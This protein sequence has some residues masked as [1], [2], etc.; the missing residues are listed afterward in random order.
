MC[1]EIYKGLQ[2]YDD[3]RSHTLLIG[4]TRANAFSLAFESEQFKL[5]F[6]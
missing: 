6:S 5:S 3:I 1:W 4:F 2:I